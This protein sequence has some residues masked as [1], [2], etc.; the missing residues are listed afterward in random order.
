MWK[1]AGQSPTAVWSVEA[2]EPLDKADICDTM[3]TLVS[4]CAL[5]MLDTTNRPNVA[6]AA[7]RVYLQRNHTVRVGILATSLTLAWC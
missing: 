2:V 4:R 7:S 5:A 1:S 6:H 3:D